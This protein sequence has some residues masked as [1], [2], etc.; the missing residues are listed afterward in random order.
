M[1]KTHIA[2]A[3]LLAAGCAKKEDLKPLQEL[4]SQLEKQAQTN[5]DTLKQANDD[6]KTCK[7]ELAEKGGS[8]DPIEVTSFE[9]PVAGATDDK[10]ALETYKTSLNDLIAKQDAEL[11]KVKA[12]SETC[13]AE[14]TALAE[15]Q[16]AAKTAKKAAPA[17]PKAEEKP[18][19]VKAAEAAG[20]P[21]KGARSRYKARTK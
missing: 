18:T 3:L 9:M 16:A 20:T 6:L 1:K 14:R 8:N 10:A 5:Q 12:A 13:T 4:T 2:L 15:K 19:A 17:K 21:S 11:T 7:T